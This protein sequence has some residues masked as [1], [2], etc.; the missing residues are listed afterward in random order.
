MGVWNMV[1]VGMVDVAMVEEGVVVQGGMLFG[2]EDEDEAMVCSQL[3]TMTMVNMML[4][5]H[6][7]VSMQVY[8]I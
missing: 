6:H 2:D 7:V 5:L 3:V 4:H 8:K 1:M